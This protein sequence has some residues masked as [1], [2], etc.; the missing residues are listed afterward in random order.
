MRRIKDMWT[1]NPQ[2]D[3]SIHIEEP[4]IAK[5]LVGGPPIGQSIVLQ[6]QQFIQRIMIAFNS[7]NRL[8]DRLQYLRLL[9]QNRCSRP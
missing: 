1:F 9:F 3:K 2:P 6:V 4:A 8:V 7:S 5:F